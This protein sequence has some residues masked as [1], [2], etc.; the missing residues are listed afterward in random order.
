MT[1]S[2]WARVFTFGVLGVLCSAT[3]LAQPTPDERISAARRTANTHPLCS[4]LVLDSFYWEIGDAS[5]RLVSGSVVKRNGAPPVDA[6]TVLGVASASK[7]IYAA[8]TIERQ[9]DV[10]A[11]R[12]FLNLTS[13]YS[14]F[15]TSDCPIEGTVAE[16]VPGERNKKEARSKVFHYD[17]GHMQRHAI[18]NGLGPLDKAGL[19]AEIASVLG[20]E[21]AATYDQ[22]GV[23]GGVRTSPA[24]YAGFLRRLMAGAEAPLQ[25]GP[26]LGSRPVCTLPS[27]TCNAARTTAVPEAWHYSLGHWVEDDPVTTP[28]LNIAYSSPG[29]FGFYPWIT[30]DRTVYG[31]LARQTPAFTGVD[32]GYASVKCGRLIRLAWQTGQPQ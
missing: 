5:G 25:L 17:G 31:L 8:F 4:P 3:A 23:A 28:A 29:S 27:A 2:A 9:G 7:W 10:P 21:L 11:A 26:L 1:R 16:C 13:G 30:A 6:D 12:S 15:R 14:N 22:P 19:S 24:R 18:D 20:D 32:E